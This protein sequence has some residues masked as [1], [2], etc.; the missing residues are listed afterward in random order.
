MTS[1][2][3]YDLYFWHKISP[4]YREKFFSFL[5]ELAQEGYLKEKVLN[6][7]KL[8]ERRKGFELVVNEFFIFLS[9]GKKWVFNFPELLELL[10]EIG[11]ELGEKSIFCGISLF[12]ALKEIEDSPEGLHEFLRLV[13][14]ILTVDVFLALSFFRGWKNLKNYVDSPDTVRKFVEEGIKIYSSRKESGYDFFEFKTE[15]AEKVAKNLSSSCFLEDVEGVVR[16]VFK[17]LSGKEIEIKNIESIGSDF[18]LQRNSKVLIFLNT[19]YLPS[20]LKFFEDQLLNRKFY[21]L[22]GITGAGMIRFRSFPSIES[23]EEL[24]ELLNKDSLFLN[25]FLLLEYVRVIESLRREWKGVWN[26][27]EKVIQKEFS[28][29]FQGGFWKEIF[30]DALKENP[31]FSISQEIKR[32]SKE[33]NSFKETLRFLSIDT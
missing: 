18:I 16:K 9:S 33:I 6:F 1:P 5:K 27:L 17:A 14:K 13:K 32:I 4:N 30:V 11:R 2:L 29:K 25:L 20:H 15:K 10:L 8:T 21:I 12:S 3:L 26:F 22:L 28:E 7:I 19:L 31:V 23:I 24:R